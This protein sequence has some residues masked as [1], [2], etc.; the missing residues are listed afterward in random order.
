[1]IL[2]HRLSPHQIQTNSHLVISQIYSLINQSTRD[3]I[4][5][6]IDGF[7]ELVRD[8]GQDESVI[9]S[10]IWWVRDGYGKGLVMRIIRMCAKYRKVFYMYRYE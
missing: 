3:S 4:P 6:L 1:M 7:K 2:Y 5:F 10:G 9:N 8:A